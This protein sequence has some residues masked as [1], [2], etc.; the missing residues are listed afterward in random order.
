MASI[1]NTPSP[2]QAR[3]PSALIGPAA[4]I[5]GLFVGHVLGALVHTNWD[6]GQPMWDEMVT[7]L[8]VGGLPEAIGLMISLLILSRG[9]FSSHAALIWLFVKIAVVM[10]VVHYL[11]IIFT[12][13]LLEGGS[14][15]NWIVDSV[16]TFP[17]FML[18]SATI[19]VP[20]AIIFS[21][22]TLRRVPDLPEL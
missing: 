21:L 15:G 8:L 14:L 3:Q 11:I 1:P 19:I 22:I 20:A 16:S 10:A 4:L 7:A 9:G 5:A 17:G 2:Y 6:F 12:V 18:Y 13:G